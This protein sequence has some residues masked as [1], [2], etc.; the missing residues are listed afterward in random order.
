LTA[1]HGGS[2]T[3]TPFPQNVF[4]KIGN[5]GLKMNSNTIGKKVADASP[6]IRFDF[7]ESQERIDSQEE[8]DINYSIRNI[9][10]STRISSSSTSS[11]SSNH[12]YNRN[13]NSISKHKHLEGNLETRDED[14][15]EGVYREMNIDGSLSLK[16]SKFLL[17]L[18]NTSIAISEGMKNFK[19]ISILIFVSR[20]QLYCLHLQLWNQQKLSDFQ[21]QIKTL[22]DL[23]IKG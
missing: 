18:I 15:R 17:V 2:T 19:L 14:N 3:S 12:N 13:H 10:H 4:S 6:G 20:D 1:T 9:N 22:L 23:M 16:V 21:H 11:S 7:D 8:K 5:V